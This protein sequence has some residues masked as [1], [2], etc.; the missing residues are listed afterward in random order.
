MPFFLMGIG[1]TIWMLWILSF[2]FF[3]ANIRNLVDSILSSATVDVVGEM[4]ETAG[5]MDFK[6]MDILLLL[7][8]DYGHELIFLATF[9]VGAVIFVRNRR[10]FAHAEILF[11]LGVVPITF[12]LFYMA[13]LSGMVP[14]L[15]S[16]NATRVQSYIFLV[17]PIFTGIFFSFALSKK[18]PGVAHLCFLLLLLPALL[19][20]LSVIPSP[21]LHRPTPDITEMDLEGM[22]WSFQ[23]K[24]VDLPYVYIMSPPYRFADIIMGRS[25]REQRPDIDRTAIKIPDHFNYSENSYFGDEY[26]NNSYA[27]I[28]EFDRVLYDTA[29]ERVG[30][31]HSED[32]D[33]LQA[34][35]TV[36]R[37]YCSNECTV[38]IV[39]GTG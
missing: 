20:V 31:F 19:T 8:K 34:D 29:Y 14:G 16:I 13:Y 22:D 33:H 11:L 27:V 6:L 39:R 3:N 25:E 21:Y 4:A 1:I 9:L 38:Y 35:P 28:T 7:I 32:F 17:V 18:W 24:D 5:K 10:R 30:R 12:G 36:D 37:L 15:D 2:R 26:T 23:Y